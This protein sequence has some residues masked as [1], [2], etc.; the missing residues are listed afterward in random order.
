MPARSKVQS[1]PKHVR[2]WL[3]SA[4]VDGNFSGY[5]ALAAEL[6]KRGCSVSKSALH[7]YGSAFEERLASLRMATEQARAVVQASPDEAGDMTEAL[8]RLVQQKTFQLLVESEV[9]PAKVNFE[10]LSL[11]VA[12][13]ARAA[14]PLKRYAAEARLKLKRVLDDAQAAAEGNQEAS[15]LALIKQIREQGYGIFE[16][17]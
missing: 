11:N 16:D 1:L 6:A 2:E 17:A 7:R 14:V 9:D 4:L 10:K 5:E 8:M 13:L 3:D 15:A 12:R